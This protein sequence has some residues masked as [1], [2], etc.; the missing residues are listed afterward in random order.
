MLE[1]LSLSQDTRRRSRFVSGFVEQPHPGCH[2]PH[3]QHPHVGR[4]QDFGFRV[5]RCGFRV[6]SFGCRVSGFGLRASG[7]VFRVSCSVFRVS[8]K[9]SDLSRLEVLE[10]DC[11]DVARLLRRHERGPRE[12]PAPHN[13]IP[14]SGFQ[15]RFLSTKFTTQ[16]DYIGNPCERPPQYNLTRMIHL[17]DLRKGT[18]NLYTATAY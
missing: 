8:G 13:L 7:F 9:G 2:V 17:I 3:R 1:S 14:D 15:K 4:P 10:L 12:R 11:S 18:G 16:F 6:S 5:W